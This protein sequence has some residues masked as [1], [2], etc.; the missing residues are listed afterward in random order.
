VH[1]R[2]TDY[3]DRLKRA[4]ARPR[5]DSRLLSLPDSGSAAAAAAARPSAG[6]EEEGLLT[7]LAAWEAALGSLVDEVTRAEQFWASILQQPDSGGGSGGGG[8]GGSATVVARRA[9]AAVIGEVVEEK[10][11]AMGGCVLARV[12]LT[13]VFVRAFAPDSD[14]QGETRAVSLVMIWVSRRTP[15]PRKAA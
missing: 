10:L 13:A 8:G 9:A 2:V 7:P 6:H 12:Y 3:M 14:T 4:T 15:R 11:I 5:R 1:R